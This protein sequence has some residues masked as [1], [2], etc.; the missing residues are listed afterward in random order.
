MIL[1]GSPGTNRTMKKTIEVMTNIVG[2]S[3]NNRGMM[4]RVMTPKTQIEHGTC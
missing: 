3:V 4:S 2:M 1:A